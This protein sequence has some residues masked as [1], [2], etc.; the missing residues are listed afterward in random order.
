MTLSVISY[1]TLE[2]LT[3]LKQSYLNDPVMK[4]L[5]QKAHEGLLSNTKF[6]LKQ[7]VLLYKN[8]LYVGE[9]LRH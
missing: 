1:P 3:E 4:D 9:G 8:I 2:W 7:G 6:V 5:V